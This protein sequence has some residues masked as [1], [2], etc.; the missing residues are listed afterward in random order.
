MVL[1]YTVWKR[2]MIF[3]KE[4]Q[5]MTLRGRR[6]TMRVRFS[7]VLAF[8][9]FFPG[10]GTSLA[11]RAETLSGSETVAVLAGRL[12]DASSGRLLT[13]QVVLIQ[14]ERIVEVGAAGRVQIPTGSSVID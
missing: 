4:D 3:E 9:L 14:G 10:I 6:E 13:N 2:T 12:F 11:L 7:S 5:A 8:L 1:L